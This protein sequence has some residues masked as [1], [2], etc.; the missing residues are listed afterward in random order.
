MKTFWKTIAQIHAGTASPPTGFAAPRSD[1]N[2]GYTLLEL[3]CV[4]AIIGI[5]AGVYLGVVAR[6]FIHVK[7]F[8]DNLFGG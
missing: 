2:S 7:K 6:A 8:L 5:L 3:L 4:I 1:G